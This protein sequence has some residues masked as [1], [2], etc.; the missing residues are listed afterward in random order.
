MVLPEQDFAAKR[1]KPRVMGRFLLTI[2]SHFAAAHRLP[3]YPGDCARVHGHTW[4]VEAS[5]A[6]QTGE[7]GMAADFKELKELVAWAI[8][9]L[10]HRMLNDL[11]AFANL[12]PTAE[13]LARHLHRELVRGLEQRGLPVRMARVTVWESPDAGATYEEE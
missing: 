8:R 3:D 4:G 12:S 5:F 10:D 11:P 2:R 9:D 6:G 13:R 7:N 1:W